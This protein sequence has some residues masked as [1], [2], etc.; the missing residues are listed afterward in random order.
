MFGTLGF[1]VRWPSAMLGHISQWE[2]LRKHNR[3]TEILVLFNLHSSVE[4]ILCIQRVVLQTETRFRDEFSEWS[5]KWTLRAKMTSLSFLPQQNQGWVWKADSLWRE[6]EIP[7]R[8][9]K[10]NWVS[11]KKSSG[12]TFLHSLMLV[13]ENFCLCLCEW[14]IIAFEVHACRYGVYNCREL[15]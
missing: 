10:H 7:T 8:N 14:K 12:D 5:R 2:D 13:T 3:Q 15:C 11:Q 1:G 4:Y 9:S 6:S